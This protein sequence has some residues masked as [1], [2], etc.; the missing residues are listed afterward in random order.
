MVISHRDRLCR[1]AFDLME[2]LFTKHAVKLVVLDQAE[3][4]S[5]DPANVQ[6][7]LA[8][9]LFSVIYVFVARNNSLR[10]AESCRKRTS[11]AEQ[12]P[13]QA[14]KKRGRPP[15]GGDGGK[16]GKEGAKDCSREDS[17]DSSLSE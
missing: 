14:K 15:K 5:S 7:E 11:Q 12:G 6:Q 10:A 9:D 4:P 2:W 3:S 1:F 13:E 8:E 17:E 16:A